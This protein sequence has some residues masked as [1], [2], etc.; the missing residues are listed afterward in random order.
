MLSTFLQGI[1]FIVLKKQIFNCLLSYLQFSMSLFHLV[2]PGETKFL[3]FPIFLN[4]R[5]LAMNFLGA[6]NATWKSCSNR[7]LNSPFCGV[8]SVWSCAWSSVTLFWRHIENRTIFKLQSFQ[9]SPFL[10]KQWTNDIIMSFLIFFLN[11]ISR[12]LS[13]IKASYC[14]QLFPLVRP[15]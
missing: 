7:V 2:F 1:F 3:K 12:K 14:Y 11:W 13:V 15:G 10:W 5:V 9:M 6:L 4:S 8:Y